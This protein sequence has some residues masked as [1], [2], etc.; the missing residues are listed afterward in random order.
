[1]V[2]SNL[3]AGRQSLGATSK[4]RFGQSITD[5]CVDLDMT[6][7]MLERLASAHSTRKRGHHEPVHEHPRQ[8]R[9]QIVS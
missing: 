5:A 1:M 8:S 3:V 7:V 6:R 2:E 4:L 9:L